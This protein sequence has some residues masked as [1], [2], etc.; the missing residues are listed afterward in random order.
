VQYL[1]VQKQ[2]ENGVIIII[3][4]IHVSLQLSGGSAFL[5]LKGFHNID[6]LQV[7]SSFSVAGSLV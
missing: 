7:K 6:T 1:K 5:V 2:Q 4:Y 3:Y